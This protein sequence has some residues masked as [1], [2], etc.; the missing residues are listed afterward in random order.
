MTAGWVA[1]STRGQALARRLLGVEAAR[2]LT[3]LDWPAALEALRSTV[4][5]KDLDAESDRGRARNEAMAATAWQLRVVAG[6]LPPGQ[7]GLARLFA[8]PIEI[9]NIEARLGYLTGG[10]EATT[11]VP[12]GSLGVAWPRVERADSAEAVRSVLA[13]SVWGDPGGVDDAT[14]GLA[15]RLGWARRCAAR[16]RLLRP[17]ARGAAAVLVARER[18]GFNRTLNDQNSRA[19]DALLGRRWREAGS[20]RDLVTSLDETASWPLAEIEDPAGLWKAEVAVA[21][22]VARESEKT[23]ASTR[24]GR[25]RVIAMLALFLIDLRLV[26]TV[27]ELAGR[28]QGTR[29]VFDAVA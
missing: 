6:W 14:V 1:V 25:Q 20:I 27:V 12:L 19:A 3:E 10:T 9:A 11:A 17:W 15:L 29:E 24:R 23:L 2:E 8:A 5:G 18:F 16:D 28:G 7:G 21:R 22:R 4:Y 13:T 26:L